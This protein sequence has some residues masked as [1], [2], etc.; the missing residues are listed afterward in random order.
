MLRIDPKKLVEKQ[1]S[2]YH[3]ENRLSPQE[4]IKLILGNMKFNIRMYEKHKKHLNNRSDKKELNYS[5]WNL[6]SQIEHI[7]N[8]DLI[9]IE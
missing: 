7:I 3:Y 9:D 2:K 1:L 8:Q 5:Q 6:I 4:K